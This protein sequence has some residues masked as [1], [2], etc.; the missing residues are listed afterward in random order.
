[1]LCG[2]LFVQFSY[3]QSANQDFEHILFSEGFA[4]AATNAIKQDL[5]GYLWFL[6]QD[7]INRYDGYEFRQFKIKNGNP[8]PDNSATAITEDPYGN[9]WIGTRLGY[10]VQIEYQ[11]NR[12]SVFQIKTDPLYNNYQHITFPVPACYSRFDRRTITSLCCDKDANLW[13]GTW[14]TGLFKF[15]TEKNEFTEHLF[16]NKD[17][18][19]ISSDFIL[20]VV[21]D[22]NGVIWSGNF[23]NGVD[24]IVTQKD[25][26]RNRKYFITNYSSGS[27]V[28]S[29]R[30]DIEN[31]NILWIGTYNNGLNKIIFSNDNE[32]D[33]LINSTSLKPSSS[34]GFKITRI[35]QDTSGN[36]WLGTIN[37]GLIQFNTRNNQTNIFKN[38]P[39][40]PASINDNDIISLEVD[41][42]GLIWAGTLS[43]YGINKLNPAKRKISHFKSGPTNQNSLSGN[44]ALSFAEDKE[45][46][47]W[48]GTYKNGLTEYNSK[49]KTFKRNP[50]HL[51]N[52]DNQTVNHITSLY[53]DNYDNLWIGTF[54]NGLFIYNLNSL[55][56]IHFDNKFISRSRITS[57]LKDKN[58]YMWIG[59]YGEGLYKA[60]INSKNEI[61]FTFYKS[62]SL[63]AGS[64]PDDRVEKIYED[65]TGIIWI[66]IFDSLLCKFDDKNEEFIT[67]KP[68][69]L[70]NSESS[71]LRIL[72]ISDITDNE[73][74]IGTAGEGL[75]IFNKKNGRLYHPENS[76]NLFS[77]IIY[78]ILNDNDSNLWLSTERG[79]IKFNPVDNSIIIYYTNDGLQENQFN[80][81]AYFKSKKGEMFFGGING[82]NCFQPDNISIRPSLSNVVISSFKVQN[83]EFVL[84][85]EPIELSY[86]DNS[87][88]ISFSVLDFTDPLK[89][90]YSYQ[91]EGYDKVW[92]YITGTEHTAL[93]SELPPGTYIFKLKGANY[94]GLWNSLPKN[95]T[96]IISPPIWKTWWVIV[97]GF[98]F[99]SLLVSYF[100]FIR[101]KQRRDLKQIQLKL[102]ADLHDTIGSGLT[103]ISILSSLAPKEIYSNPASAK[104]KLDLISERCNALIGSMSDIVWLI[105]PKPASLHDLILRLRDI[106]SLLCDSLGISL[107]ITNLDSLENI[108]LNLNDR[109]N[110]YLIFKEA[111][112]NS[113]KY[114]GCKTI[115]FSMDKDEKEFCFTLKDDGKGFDPALKSSGNGLLNM[116]DR[117]K[118]LKGNL[119]I[120]SSPATGTIIALTCNLK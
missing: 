115:S 84:T 89:N 86:N 9:I 21:A 99:I 49:E 19:S 17:V 113:I 110:I 31:K 114:S 68:V 103:E 15:D 55:K 117:A 23:T 100:V 78:G 64:L 10:L 20:S 46:N 13:I 65:K 97:T 51:I 33:S 116:K 88:L 77:K 59:T 118:A 71:T 90:Q 109:Q 25:K 67:Y 111:I 76:T 38:D 34:S 32:N 85:D 96:I 6:T 5:Q 24:K 63:Y 12:I 70:D 108:T 26:K 11:S 61:Y 94:T 119:E 14:G 112:N 16:Q 47:I 48:I 7:G 52:S 60:A 3:S 82:I 105:N 22:K 44:V 57:I 53:C 62:S 54:G 66:A 28:T 101:I 69:L 93:Y 102:S 87:I 18:N 56:Q 58:G 45:G 104:S 30:I 37:D 83:R 107:K 72:S 75:F 50:F 73:L 91:L 42:T 40:N 81:G 74:W 36:L 2:F 8:L 80:N 95:I 41:K 92:H 1:M 98:L 35:C 120:L 43:G 27:N 4:Q 106:Y 39:L 29:L 79:I